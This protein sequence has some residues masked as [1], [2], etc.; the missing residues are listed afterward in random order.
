VAAQLHVGFVVVAPDRRLLEGPVHAFDLAVGPGVLGLGQAVV[1]VVLRTGEL[2][3]MGAEGLA[4]LQ[5]AFD[6][7][8]RRALVAGGGEVG[9][10]VGQDG[11]NLVG[12]RLEQ[13]AQE[14]PFV[15]FGLPA[16]GRAAPRA[17]V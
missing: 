4:G 1:D 2:E 17:I 12:N 9:A 15:P 16:P 6:V 7:G 8:C 3:S 10:V 11:V 14:V 5:G 13:R